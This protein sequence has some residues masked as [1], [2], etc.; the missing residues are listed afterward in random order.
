MS[1]S[2]TESSTF[3]AVILKGS[4]NLS[5]WQLSLT[6][7]LLGKGLIDCIQE[8]QP[9]APPTSASA[10]QKKDY[11]RWGTALKLNSQSV[12]L[13]VANDFGSAIVIA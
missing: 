9:T 6:S 4:D 1:N 12:C 8:E 3:K 7:A 5:D 11:Q 10:A 13:R 2:E